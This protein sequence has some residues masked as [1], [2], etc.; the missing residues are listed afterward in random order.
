MG[1]SMMRWVPNSCTS[2][3]SV[4]GMAGLGHVLADEEHAG[5][6]PHLLRSRL[7]HRLAV[8]PKLPHVSHA[9]LPGP[10]RLRQSGPESRSL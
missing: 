5:I 3:T 9:H 2:P 8:R 1:V 6:A 7:L 4:E 10:L